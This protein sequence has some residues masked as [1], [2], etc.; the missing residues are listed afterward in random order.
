M[1]NS[2][3]PAE[4]QDIVNASPLNVPT[5]AVDRYAAYYSMLVSC[6]A[7]VET[8]GLSPT[9]Q[10]A[11]MTAFLLTIRSGNHLRHESQG[12]QISENYTSS[13]QAALMFAAFSLTSLLEGNNIT[14]FIALEGALVSMYAAADQCG[15]AADA[16]NTFNNTYNGI[17]EK[18]SKAYHGLCGLF[19]SNNQEVAAQQT[20]VNTPGL[21]QEQSMLTIR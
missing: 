10:L 2:R 7:M 12:E 20:T 17:C 11:A 1:A 15:V 4:N 19:G 5:S 13:S 3:I 8:G 6:S 9:N 16:I 18:A 14:S 21:K